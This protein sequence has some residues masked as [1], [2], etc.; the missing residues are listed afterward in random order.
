MRHAGDAKAAKTDDARAQP[1]GG[2]QIV[3]R[4]GQRK[5]EIGA[6]DGKLGVA[7]RDGVSGES[8]EIAQVF[9][10]APAIPASAVGASEPRDAHAGAGRKLGGGSA[11]DLADNLMA[12]NNTLESKGQLAFHNVQV[13]TT[14]TA[15]AHSQQHLS[16]P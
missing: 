6:G 1:R 9:I 10:A 7:T 11:H 2:V 13:G 5:N 14:N 16:D 15:G 3:E 8:R 12:G 4:G